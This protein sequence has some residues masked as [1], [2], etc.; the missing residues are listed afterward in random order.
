MR[1]KEIKRRPKLSVYFENAIQLIAHAHTSSEMTAALIKSPEKEKFLDEFR[2]E[3]FSKRTHSLWCL[4]KQIIHRIDNC[5]SGDIPTDF[6][7]IPFGLWPN[8]SRIILSARL[9]CGAMSRFLGKC[10]AFD[11]VLSSNSNNDD[12]NINCSC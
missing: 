2:A 5:S 4:G 9:S 12:D 11:S 6:N 3:P 10:C 8:P 1:E 7:S